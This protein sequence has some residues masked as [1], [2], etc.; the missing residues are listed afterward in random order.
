MGRNQ[1]MRDVRDCSIPQPPHSRTMAENSRSLL[2][3][4]PAHR[5]GIR[6]RLRCVRELIHLDLRNSRKSAAQRA[7]VYTRDIPLS[8]GE[9][10]YILPARGGRGGRSRALAGPNL[11]P[12]KSVVADCRNEPRTAAGQ[13]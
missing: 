5:G 9:R 12:R 8:E 11:S 6:A 7:R 2:E 10:G 3:A 1:L 4:G 13:S